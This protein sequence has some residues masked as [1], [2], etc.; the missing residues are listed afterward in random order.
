MR[1]S[2]SQRNYTATIALGQSQSEVIDIEDA[3][4]G[5]YVLPAVFTNTGATNL[6]RFGVSN[7][8]QAPGGTALVALLPSTAIATAQSQRGTISTHYALPPDLF[9]F[10]GFRFDGVTT[11]LQASLIKCAFKTAPTR[12][13]TQVA[14]IAAGQTVSNAVN[15]AQAIGGSVL[16]PAAFTGPTLAFQ[17][18]LDGGTYTALPTSADAAI[19]QGVAVDRHIPIPDGAFGFA[20]LKLVSGASETPARYLTVTLKR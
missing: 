1:T 16:V 7:S 14:T 12:W 18:S 20:W 4:S 10:R 8:L 2:R 13:D 17:V 6:L 11:E 15:I 3:V 5:G 9:K 19:S